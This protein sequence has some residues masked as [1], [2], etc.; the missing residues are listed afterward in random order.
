M[1]TTSGKLDLSDWREA[2]G[3]TALA[4]AY[5]LIIALGS[6]P[7]SHAVGGLVT[8]GVSPHT[9]SNCHQKVVALQ[10]N[11]RCIIIDLRIFVF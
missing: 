2:I 4:V 9:I 10:N 5:G 3:M 6:T 7:I 1:R 11:G 8:F